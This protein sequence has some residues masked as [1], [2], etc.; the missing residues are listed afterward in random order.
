MNSKFSGVELLNEMTLEEEYE[1]RNLLYA[2]EDMYNKLKQL[3]GS[4]LSV[5]GFEGEASAIELILNKAEG[6]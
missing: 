1:K 2:A 6:K 3:R 5:P 4:F